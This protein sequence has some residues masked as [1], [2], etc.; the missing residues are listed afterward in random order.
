MFMIDDGS[1]P[2]VELA[3]KD[4]NIIAAT[5]TNFLL[6]N[7][8]RCPNVLLDV[9]NVLLDGHLFFFLTNQDQDL[10]NTQR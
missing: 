1:Q 8:G 5:F 10:L 7:I 2:P 6:K 3:A 4:R 9:P